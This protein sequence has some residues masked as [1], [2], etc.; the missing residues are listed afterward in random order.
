M[1]RPL[2][3]STEAET[4][5][6]SLPL[7]YVENSTLTPG[8]I[9]AGEEFVVKA[10]LR[11]TSKT[12]NIRKIV[13]SVSTE[14]DEIT[15]L[16]QSNT[17]YWERMKAGENREL[18]LHFRAEQAVPSFRGQLQL[19]PNRIQRDFFPAV[20]HAKCLLLYGLLIIPEYEG[21]ILRASE[22]RLCR[23]SSA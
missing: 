20:L 15:L 1:A 16:E 14:S 7:L 12:Q 18:P 5:P 8:E 6:E 13:I 23:N 9:S 19:K 22:L 3:T 10:S 11:N 4:R 17:I 2:E 21:R